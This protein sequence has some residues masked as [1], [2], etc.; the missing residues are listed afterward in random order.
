M[1]TF[2]PDAVGAS[3]L[4]SAYFLVDE[5]EMNFDRERNG[6]EVDVTLGGKFQQLATSTEVNQSI[7]AMG[8]P[9]AATPAPAPREP[10][11]R[12]GG[13]GPPSASQLDEQ[14]VQLAVQRRR[15][16]QHHRRPGRRPRRPVTSSPASVATSPP[17]A[18]SHGVEAL[19][20]V[21]VDPPLGGGA[22]VQRGRAEPP[23]VAH[24]RQHAGQHRGLV[25]P[26]GRV[27]AEAG[28]DQSAGPGLSPSSR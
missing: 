27:V 19:L 18:W 3:W 24:P 26:A 20:E 13:Q 17:A 25:R 10:S 21:R 11:P 4:V 8:S 16:G 6:A 2:G 23:D 28:G 9:R 5:A 1:I 14:V 12:R 7:A 15:A 22:Q